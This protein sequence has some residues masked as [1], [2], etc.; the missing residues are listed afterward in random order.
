MDE[1]ERVQREQGIVKK[2]HSQVVILWWIISS[3][4]AL[5]MTLSTWMLK[6]IISKDEILLVP[7]TALSLL[8]VVFIAYSIYVSLAT[9]VEPETKL[10]GR[11]LWWHGAGWTLAMCISTV[12]GLI[13]IVASK[14]VSI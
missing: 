14:L 6:D 3:L 11:L 5:V 8:Y 9:S 13:Y 2:H 1:H 10:S 4:V 7:F 12:G